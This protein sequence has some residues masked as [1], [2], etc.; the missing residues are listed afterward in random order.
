MRFRFFQGSAAVASP[1]GDAPINSV[2]IG[3]VRMMRSFRLGH[4]LGI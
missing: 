1:R 4:K 3:L 2:P